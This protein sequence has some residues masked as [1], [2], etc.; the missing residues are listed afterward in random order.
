MR[1]TPFKTAEAN[2]NRKAFIKHHA[3]LANEIGRK[4][5]VSITAARKP[6]NLRSATR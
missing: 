5:R 3:K 2:R 1:F 6:A 4:L